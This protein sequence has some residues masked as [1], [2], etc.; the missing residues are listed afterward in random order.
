MKE[1]KSFHHGNLRNAMVKQGLDIIQEEGLKGIS[2]RKVTERCGVSNP[3]AYRHFKNKQELMETLFIEV[4]AF[5][6]NYLAVAKEVVSPKER[7]TEM[8]V[9]FVYFSKEYPNYYDFLFRST[10]MEPVA[11]DSNEINLSKQQSGFLLFK[12]EVYD[13][14]DFYHIEGNR[15]QHLLHLWAYVS[16]LAMIGSENNIFFTSK[17]L[18][19][20]Q[21]ENMMQIYTKGN[22]PSIEK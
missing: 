20:E 4:A 3:S 8:G 7:L 2:L 14:L 13:Y 10:F 22:K 12:K 1:H 19:K 18:I 6:N 11:F 15:G 16:G 9:N 17:D 5:F 21:V